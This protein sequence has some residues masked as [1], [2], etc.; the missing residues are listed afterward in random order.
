[1]SGP[2]V[3]NRVRRAFYLDSV[4]LM[5]LSRELSALPGVEEATWKSDLKEIA[6]RLT[7]ICRAVDP[8]STEE[9][10]KKAHAA[11]VVEGEEHAKAITA[12]TPESPSPSAEP[13]EED[14]FGAGIV[15]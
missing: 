5:R 3:I 6:D 7:E 11:D 1:M 14:A 13:E 2:R 9:T 10:I 8:T 12:S 15:D 4:A